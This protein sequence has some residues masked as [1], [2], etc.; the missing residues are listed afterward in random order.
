MNNLKILL[1]NNINLLLGKLQGKKER[2]KAGIAITLLTF[3][4]VGIL[5]LYSLQAY[6]MFKGLGALGL[7]DLC[8]FHAFLTALSVIVILG[9]MRVGAG[10]KNSDDDLLLSLPIKKS[11]IIISKTLNKYVFDLFFS[12]TLIL[13]Y[14][15]LYQ[16][17][18]SFNAIILFKG[19]LCIFL[20]PLLSVGISYVLDFVLARSF[21][22]FKNGKMFKTILTILV[23]VIVMILMLVKTFF[24]GSVNPENMQTYFSDRF[25]S[26][27]FLNF[28]ISNNIYNLFGVLSLTII[29]FILGMI[30][31]SLNYGK[32]FLGY[33][34]NNKVLKFNNTNS[35]IGGLLKK[36]ISTYF[37]TIP[38]ISNTIIGSLF[39]LVLSILF[40][41][42]GIEKIFAYLGA[43]I[44]VELLPA[45][46][47]VILCTL[48]ST[49]LISCSSISLEGKNFWIIK[50]S[51]INEKH[52]LLAKSLL[53]I[54][55]T[56]PFI[57][58]GTT[59]IAITMHLSFLDMITLI[60]FPILLTFILSFSGV[61][62][63]LYFPVLEFEDETKVVKQSFSTLLTMLLG[64]ILSALL[65][66]IYFLF[67]FLPIKYI[68]LI[69]ISAYILILT[70]VVTLLFTKGI[71]KIRT[72][73]L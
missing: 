66:G 36:E 69:S 47:S 48:V 68:L 57:I 18:S 33:K 20:L 35:S 55:I 4:V 72:I 23:F 22:K 50:S 29:P 8:L 1:K 53:Q 45:L 54:I 28:L 44:S 13:P 60:T 71:K 5:L 17:F 43:T 19:L 51:P 31:Y 59:I 62:I 14:I 12:T 30:L 11:D 26:N 7:N 15:I 42:M 25:F 65:V 39:I 32:T 56:L 27:L 38:W 6:S 49:T 10:N 3:G 63:N 61:L 58:I 73:Q 52:L 67:K 37:S 16:I 70:T 2:K 64:I 40:A 41:T 46:I 24:Y 21:N 9:I 34:S